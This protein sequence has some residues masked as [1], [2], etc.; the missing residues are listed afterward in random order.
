M[1]L[2]L[3]PGKNGRAATTKV[4]SSG[5]VVSLTWRPISTEILCSHPTDRHSS[6]RIWRLGLPEFYQKYCGDCGKL[7]SQDGNLADYD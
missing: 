6:T 3:L 7:L 5:A 1:S 2:I 4:I